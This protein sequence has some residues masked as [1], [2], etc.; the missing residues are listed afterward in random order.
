MLSDRHMPFLTRELVKL[1]ASSS[2]FALL[3]MWNIQASN[4]RDPGSAMRLQ[5][6]MINLEF[7]TPHQVFDQGNRSYAEV[8]EW[9][10][11]ERGRGEGGWVWG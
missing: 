6:A 9:G 1:C 11:V 5:V 3:L 8:A 2:H 7:E 10:K 4:L